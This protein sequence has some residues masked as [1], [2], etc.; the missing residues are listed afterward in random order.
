MKSTRR[1]F[2]K[3][4]LGFCLVGIS[5]KVIGQGKET[6]TS[7]YMLEPNEQVIPAIKWDSNKTGHDILKDIE[8]LKNRISAS[9]GIPKHI[10]YGKAN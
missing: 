3:G 2:L 8:D 6:Y 10:L 1:Q 7:P 5:A 4:L 9:T